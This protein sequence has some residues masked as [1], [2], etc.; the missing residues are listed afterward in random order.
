MSQNLKQMKKQFPIIT[1][2]LSSYPEGLGYYY[3][4]FPPLLR[5]DFYLTR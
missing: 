3:D 1:H 4:L 5:L 2:N